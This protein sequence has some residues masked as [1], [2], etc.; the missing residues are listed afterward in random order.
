MEIRT[1]TYTLVDRCRRGAFL[2][3]TSN[4]CTSAVLRRRVEAVNVH[5]VHVRIRAHRVVQVEPPLTSKSLHDDAEPGRPK[6]T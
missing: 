5:R 3:Q 4:A 6:V 2:Q 1:H